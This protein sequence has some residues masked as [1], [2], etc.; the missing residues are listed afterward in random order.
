MTVEL[1]NTYGILHIGVAEFLFDL[2]DLPIIKGR[3]SWY[4]DKDGYLVSSYFYCGVRRFVRFH[5]LVM[6]A[7]PG[8]FVDHINKNKADNRKENLRCCQRSENDRNRS[9]Y[10]TNTSG[11]SGVFFDR[12]REKWVAS[13]TYNSKKVY[14]GRYDAKEDA[15]MARLTKRLSFIGSS[16]LKKHSWRHLVFAPTELWHKAIGVELQ[17]GTYS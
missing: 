12:Q 4:C 6:H 15:I 13:I 9:L 10:I 16:P 1:L 8:Q 5:R 14:L 11:V 3:D 17:D 7:K 2:D